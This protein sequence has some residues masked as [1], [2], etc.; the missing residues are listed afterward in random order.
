MWFSSTPNPHS[1]YLG[2]ALY[3][4][5][6]GRDLVKGVEHA[7]CGD[8]EISVELGLSAICASIEM[9]IRAFMILE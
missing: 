7:V 5:C 9:Y 8:V 3:S 1:N 6:A 4:H 2:T